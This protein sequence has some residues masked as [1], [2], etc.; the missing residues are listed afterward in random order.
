MIPFTNSEVVKECTLQS[1]KVMEGEDTFLNF[2]KA[3]V[4][5]WLLI[6]IPIFQIYLS[7]LFLSDFLMDKDLSPA[8]ASEKEELVG[9]L[10]QINCTI[11]PYHCIINNTVLFAILSKEYFPLLTEIAKLAN[12]L[13][14]RSALMHKNLK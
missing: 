12:F 4:F 5:P 11:V 1:V 3:V 9:K 8:M 14:T 6:S 7:C 2:H 13:W 10:K